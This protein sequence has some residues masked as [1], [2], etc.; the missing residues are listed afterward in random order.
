MDAIPQ[1]S[2]DFLTRSSFGFHCCSGLL[3]SLIMQLAQ[4]ILTFESFSAQC[5]SNGCHF[6]K[7]C[8]LVTAKG[9]G[10]EVGILTAHMKSFVPQVPENYIHVTE[11]LKQPLCI[12]AHLRAWNQKRW[13]RRIDVIFSRELQLF[14]RRNTLSLNIQNWQYNDIFNS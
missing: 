7:S 8:L 11:H 3:Q 14:P 1:R 13:C 6:A 10:F 9:L 2:C 12:A 5:F 4:F